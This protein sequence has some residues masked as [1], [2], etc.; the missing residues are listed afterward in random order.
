[1]ILL[2]GRVLFLLDS[3]PRGSFLVEYYGELIDATEGHERERCDD[4]VF[5]YFIRHKK[6]Q[7]WYV[8]F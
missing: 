8:L 3:K 2:T 7:W 4:S 5:R 1:M 6:K